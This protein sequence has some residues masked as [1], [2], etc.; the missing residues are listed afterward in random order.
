[1][2]K[3]LA[4]L[5]S[6]IIEGL[7]TGSYRFA[8]KA[9]ALKKLAYL[10]SKFV[11]SRQGT[12]MPAAEHSLTLWIRGYGLSDDDRAKGYVGHFASVTIE[13]LPKNKNYALKAVKLDVPLPAHPKRLRPRRST[14]DMGHYVLRRVAKNW[15]YA[16]ME[17][18]D[19]DLKALA[20]DYPTVSIPGSAKLYIMIYTKAAKGEAPVQRYVLQVV[21]HEQGGFTITMARNAFVRKP[22]AKKPAQALDAQVPQGKFTAAVQVRRARKKK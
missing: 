18:A 10:R 19:A 13:A 5:Q 17:D 14:P 9:D 7:L 11:I 20:T 4:A 8:T 6:P 1:M 3:I 22:A 15:W 16:T 12:Q 21:P 2:P